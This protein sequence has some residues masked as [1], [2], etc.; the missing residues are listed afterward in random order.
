MNNFNIQNL[1]K[2]TENTEISEHNLDL[3]TNV[4]NYV[5]LLF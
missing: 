4:N 2:Q 3:L 5:L 1:S